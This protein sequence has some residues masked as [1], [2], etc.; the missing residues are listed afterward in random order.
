MRTVVSSRP[1]RLSVTSVVLNLSAVLLIYLVPTF[2]HLLNLPL[3]FIEPM[4]L[5]VILALVH[6]NARNAFF[7][8]VTLPLFSFLTSGHPH[9][10]K[11]L[12]II[13][14]LS[15]NVW[16]YTMLSRSWRNVF[17]AMISAIILSKGIYYL[18]KFILI[19]LALIESGLIATPLY[20]QAITLVA[21]SVYAF[22]VLRNRTTNSSEQ[23]AGA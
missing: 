15:L 7:L 18:A 21:F 22:M 8:A 19:Q 14:E 12:L 11:M 10:L 9:I 20:I 5:M 1:S 2:S 13:A 4:R 23:E 6:T 17:G 3:Y 16:I